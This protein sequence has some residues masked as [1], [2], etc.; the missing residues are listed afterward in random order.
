MPKLKQSSQGLTQIIPVRMDRDTISYYRQRAN[1]KGVSLSEF[2]RQN[3]VQGMIAESAADI[4]QRLQAMSAELT[5][6]AS[7]VGTLAIPESV[8]LSV[9]TCEN[10][11]TKII[12][13]RNIQEL[14]DAQNRAR[15]RLRTE[16][17]KERESQKMNGVR[18][19]AA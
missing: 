5:E 13:A 1:E 7:G 2:L 18:H 15:D 8:L 3:I 17:E 10:I 11:L 16:K 6:K 14:Y 12:E 9:Y 19:V 4:E